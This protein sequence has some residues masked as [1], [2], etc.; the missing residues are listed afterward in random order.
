MTTDAEKLGD[1]L[2]EESSIRITSRDA[3]FLSKLM[4]NPP[5]PNAYLLAAAAGLK[6]RAV[7]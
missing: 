1:V 5:E 4:E 3:E 7:E 2:A 6:S